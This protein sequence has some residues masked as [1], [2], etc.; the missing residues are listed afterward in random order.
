MRTFLL[1]SWMLFLFRISYFSFSQ[2]LP[3][4][5]NTSH[6]I[7]CF[8]D[9]TGYK[10]IKVGTAPGDNY[11]AANL[12]TAINSATL[13]PG[14]VIVLDAGIIFTGNYSLPNIAS[15]SGWVIITGSKMNKLPAE[16]GRVD[17]T[18]SSLMPKIITSNVNYPAI[19][20]LAS[21][22]NYRIMGVEIGIAPTA[23][24]SYGLLNLGDGSSKQNSLSTVPNNLIIDRCYIHGNHAV[25]DTMFQCGVWLN[26]ANTAIVN[27]FIADIHSS[28]QNVE[29]HAIGIVNGP[30]PFKIVNNYL[31]AGGECILIGG[32]VP[33]IPNLVPSDI[34]VR[35]NHFFKPLDWFPKSKTFNG[36]SCY[37]KNHFELKTGVRVLVDGNIFENNWATIPTLNA[38]QGGSSILI[39]VRSLQGGG[40]FV[41]I[42]DV[43]IT[44]N[45]IKHCGAGI[46]LTGH[47]SEQPDDTVTV[48]VN[49]SNNLFEDINGPVYGDG[50]TAGPNIGTWLGESGGPGPNDVVFNHNTVFQTG[51]ITWTSA[52]TEA[53][54]FTN[55]IFNSYKASDG[56]GIWGVGVSKDGNQIL[57]KYYPDITDA[58]EHF[59]RNVLIGGIAAN[60]SNDSTISKNYFPTDST[61]VGFVNYSLGISN[62]QNYELTAIS[63]YHNM[64]TDGS[65]IGVNFTQLAIHLSDTATCTT[66]ITGIAPVQDSQ[67]KMFVFPNPANSQISVSLTGVGKMLGAFISLYDVSGKLVCIQKA[68]SETVVI[69]V[70]ALSP[71][72]YF[73]QLKNAEG[74]ITARKIVIAK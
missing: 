41:H 43:T 57:T 9:T 71:G 1:L 28:T 68:D 13:S 35:N 62:Y 53:N 22:H 19:Q 6:I 10:V 61:K 7:T 2:T 46:G 54:V 69:D 18:Q 4:L 73:I 70:A 30:G 27:S 23:H 12:Q 38:A 8:P 39:T 26:S 42:S 17:S 60:Y 21:A 31:S 16:N 63:W 33:A 3:A 74:F 45:I 50:Q 24:Y 14:T 66:T 44:N 49:I 37:I 67:S 25:H 58:G 52:V 51:V 32:G 20:T 36:D 40:Y 15:G 56:Q 48:R 34:E 55:N 47:D 59:D 29:G 65:D 64:A 5:P 11:N 72:L